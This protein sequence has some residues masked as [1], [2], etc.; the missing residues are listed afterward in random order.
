MWAATI[1]IFFCIHVE[2]LLLWT[3]THTV[4]WDWTS[5]DV[6]QH[7]RYYMEKLSIHFFKWGIHIVLYSIKIY[8]KFDSLTQ[9]FI[10]Q[11]T[12]LNDI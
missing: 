5:S 3:A 8:N 12:Y 10:V 9:L 11:N 2:I 1:L 6:C 7:S 4:I